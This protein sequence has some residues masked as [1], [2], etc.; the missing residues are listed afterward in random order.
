MLDDYGSYLGMEKGCFLVKDREGKTERYPM[1]ENEIGEVILKSGNCVSTG[2]LASL[3]FWGID[4]L[5]MTQK[6][7]PVAMLKSLDDDS[8]VK[9]RVCQYEAL[10]NEKAVHIAKQLVLSKF[11]GQNQVLKKYGLRRHDFSIQEKVKNLQDENTSRLRIRLMAIEGH[12]SDHYFTQIFSLV[13]ASLRPQSRKTFNAYDGMNNV[14][15][16]A[17][18]MLSWKVHH[19]LINAKLEPYLGFLHSMAEGKPSLVCDFMELYRYLVD[20]FIIQHCRRLQ[21]RD[22]MMKNEDF[23]TNRR[24]K[25]EYL[26][27]SLTRSLVRSLNEYFESKVEI[28]RIRMGKKQEIETLIHEEALLLAMYL[29]N[30]RK[31][32]TPRVGIKD[33]S[34]RKHE[35]IGHKL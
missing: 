31:E 21:K 7:K 18:E 3:G 12:F 24:G 25:R 29:R 35:G 14:F 30:E 17:Y 1:F 27:D 34:W 20:D 9:T 32:W 10:N 4:T 2:A 16:L 5:I 15:N 22:F 26:N 6:G 23:S 28:R 19:A 11:E 13:P 33:D 8:H